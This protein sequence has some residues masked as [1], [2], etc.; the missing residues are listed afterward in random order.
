[1]HVPCMGRS[2]FEEGWSEVPGDSAINI[3]A[4]VVRTRTVIGTVRVRWSTP[5]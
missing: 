2:P 1:M 4:A 5:A 3:T